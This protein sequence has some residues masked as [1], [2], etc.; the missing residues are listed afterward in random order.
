MRFSTQPTA[1]KAKPQYGDV[2]N[3]WSRTSL[4]TQLS[5][6]Q[7][8]RFERDFVEVDAIGSGEFGSAIKVQYKYAHGVKDRIYAVKKSRRFEGNRHR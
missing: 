3:I 6:E 1:G 7:L 8:G 2:R 4:P 5:Y